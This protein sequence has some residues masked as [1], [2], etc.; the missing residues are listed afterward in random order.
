M[1]FIKSRINYLITLNFSIIYFS[2]LKDKIIY[3]YEIAITAASLRVAGG[4]GCFVGF[5]IT[6]VVAP[7]KPACTYTSNDFIYR[8]TIT[9]F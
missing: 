1:K 2:Q 8:L 4:T 9:S 5:L 6:T 3:L 7:L